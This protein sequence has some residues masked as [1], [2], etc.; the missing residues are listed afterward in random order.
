MDLIVVRYKIYK[1][2]ELKYNKKLIRTS[3]FRESLNATINAKH[4][5]VINKR[6]A[7]VWMANPPDILGNI[8]LSCSL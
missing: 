4:N 1:K 3:N 7:K 8:V 5:V 2:I 6:L